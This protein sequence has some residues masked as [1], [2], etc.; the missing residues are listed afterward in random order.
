[1]NRPFPTSLKSAPPFAQVDAVLQHISV[2]RTRGEKE[3]VLR[4][5]RRDGPSVLSFINAHGMNL[6]WS[7]PDFM[8]AFLEA[9]VL[10]RDGVGMALFMRAGGIDPGLNLNGTD[11]IPEILKMHK[12]LR[13]ALAGT[14][15]PDVEEAGARLESRYG[16][17]VIAT[18]DGFESD[19]ATYSSWAQEHRPDIIV[20]GMGMPKQER[21]SMRLQADLTYT[22]TIING[23]AILD[24][25]AGRVL[26][27]P[28]WVRATRLEW[29]Y[30]LVR[31]PGRLWQR[32]LVGNPVHVFHALQFR[33]WK[34]RQ[35]PH[36]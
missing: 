25:L 33:Q 2:A 22:C 28:K 14:R 4:A 11:L 13:I 7:D 17:N 3:A 15:S 8:D 30:R 12:D 27:A 20:L 26:R 10:V 9:D 35:S 16:C 18:I 29:G 31:E 19:D 32:Y 34:G 36:I 24:F 21:I 6:A 5:L 23:G 1:M